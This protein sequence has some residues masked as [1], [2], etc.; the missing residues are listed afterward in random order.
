MRH[1]VVAWLRQILV[2]ALAHEVRRYH[3]AQKRDVTLEVSLALHLAIFFGVQIGTV[4]RRGV[5]RQVIE[6]RLMPTPSRASA[7]SKP[8]PSS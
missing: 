8:H 3:G 2:H 6:A 4:E 7:A 1:V 5:A